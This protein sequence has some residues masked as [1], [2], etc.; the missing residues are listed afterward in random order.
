MLGLPFVRTG[1]EHGTVSDIA[2]WVIADPACFDAA[3]TYAW[4]LVAA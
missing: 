3:I 2:G 1:P 4:R